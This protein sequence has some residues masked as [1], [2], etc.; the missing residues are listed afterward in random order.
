[1]MHDVRQEDKKT[2]NNKTQRNKAIDYEPLI[3]HYDTE[4][5]KHNANVKTQSTKKKHMNSRKIYDKR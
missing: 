2:T 5:R 1:M 4:N 3:L